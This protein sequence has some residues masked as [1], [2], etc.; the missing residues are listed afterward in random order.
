MRL[1]RAYGIVEV[2][3]RRW[4]VE[5]IETRA[6]VFVWARLLLRP[7][8]TNDGKEAAISRNGTARMEVDKVEHGLDGTDDAWERRQIEQL[9]ESGVLL[10]L[11]REYHVAT[12]WR[13]NGWVRIT[14]ALEEMRLREGLRRI[15]IAL[16]L[17]KREMTGEE[18][19]ENGDGPHA[20]VP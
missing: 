17:E 11:G 7:R 9:R 19:K 2:Q 13:E 16:G 18:K 20:K 6:G 12:W 10:S 1:A 8:T 3:L 15:G 5:F 14:F 4:G